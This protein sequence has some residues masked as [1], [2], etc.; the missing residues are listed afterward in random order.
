MDKDV[1]NS[2]VS[3]ETVSTYSEVNSQEYDDEKNRQFLY[4]RKTYEFV[5]QIRFDGTRD[6]LS[7]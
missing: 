1:S 6:W 2:I 5:K 3:H 4:G 7:G